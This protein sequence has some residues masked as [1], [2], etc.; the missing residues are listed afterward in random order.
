MARKPKQDPA[1]IP[2]VPVVKQGDDSI[3]VSAA[4]GYMQDPTTLE[5][6]TGV[7]KQVKKTRWIEI[8]LAAGKLKLVE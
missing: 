5:G 8:Q 1:P 4:Y 7:P 2:E 3:T 6:F